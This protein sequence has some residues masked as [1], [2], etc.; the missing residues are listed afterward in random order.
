M[1]RTIVTREIIAPV[2][3]GFETIAN[4]EKYSLA[5]PHIVRVEFLSDIR[6]GL[7]TRFCETRLMHGKEASTELEVTE[8]SLDQHIRLVADSHGTLWDTL[9]EVEKS[10]TGTLL[11]LTMDATAHQFLPRI[12]N[13]LIKGMVRKA[14][15]GDMDM[16]KA[17]CEN[18]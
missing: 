18:G 11:T 14:I 6:S 2:S 7:G 5:I 17:Y 4:I 15:E 9:F 1:S 12:I 8:Y 13:P 3:H 10:E 16:V